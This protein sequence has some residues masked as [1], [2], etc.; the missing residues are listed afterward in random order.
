[1]RI[2]SCYVISEEGICL[3][4]LSFTAMPDKYLITAMLAAMQAFIT[5]VSGDYAKKVAAAEF[6][7]HIEKVGKISIVL[8][9]SS[10]ERPADQLSN[11]RTSFLHKFGAE[12]ANFTG[13][14]TKFEDFKSDAEEILNLEGIGPRI[15]PS[16][17]LNAFVI[18]SLDEDLREIA[19]ELI[20]VEEAT[21][22]ELSDRLTRSLLFTKAVLEKLVTMGHIG[23]IETD[24]GLRYFVNR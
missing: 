17:P 22:I 9:T 4:D 11:L 20:I 24:Q 5:E 8:A 3:F 7:F 12:L 16:Q 23:R 13:V 21:A 19:K 2:Y 10:D 6:V 15:E 18:M 14:I 1:M